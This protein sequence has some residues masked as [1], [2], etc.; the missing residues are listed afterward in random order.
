[1]GLLFPVVDVEDII[2]FPDD[3][4][5]KRY[6]NV[7]FKLFKTHNTGSGDFE[8]YCQTRMIVCA[9]QRHK[10]KRKVVIKEGLQNIDG[11]RIIIVDDMVQTGGTIISCAKLLRSKGAKRVDAFVT[12]GVFPKRSWQRFLSDDIDH[13]YV[14]DSI[15]KNATLPKEKFTVLSIAPIVRYLALDTKDSAYDAMIES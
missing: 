4:A 7:F 5:Q 15:P 2:A 13:F 6:K 8:S 12:H 9:K 1:M 14:T 3:G 11:K 10:D